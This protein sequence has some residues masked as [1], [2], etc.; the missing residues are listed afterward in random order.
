MLDV[1]LTEVEIYSRVWKTSIVT[2]AF[3]IT[4]FNNGTWI[5]FGAIIYIGISKWNSIL[6]V[7]KDTHI[8]FKF[9]LNVDF[10]SFLFCNKISLFYLRGYYDYERKI[11]RRKYFDSAK[12]CMQTS[13]IFSLCLI[14]ME[15]VLIDK[16]CLIEK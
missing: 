13:K 2:L 9:Q 1:I 7:L 12:K 11:I 15:L 6:L 5:L 14:S 3:S 10:D 8:G 16:Q 4:T